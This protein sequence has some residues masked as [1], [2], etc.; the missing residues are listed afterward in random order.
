[1]D[2]SGTSKSRDGS[3]KLPPVVFA[4]YAADQEQLQHAFRL[5]ESIRTFAGRFKDAPVWAYMPP[6]LFNARPDLVERLRLLGVECRTS[7]APHESLRFHYTGKVFASGDAEASA[8]G[9][10]DLLVWMDSDTFVLDEP[11]EFAIPDTVSFAYRPV[12]HNRSGSAWGQSPDLFWSR[13]Y[14][15]LAISDMDLF[16][17]K[18]PADEIEIRT[19]FNAGLVIVR[20]ER[21]ILRQWVED[22][23]LLYSDSTLAEMCDADIEKRIFIHQTALVGA[24][25]SVPREEMM[26]LS[27]RYNYPIFFHRQFHAVH[28]FDS[29]ENIVTLRYDVYF[30]DPDPD[31]HL[32]LK[33]PKD[34]IDWLVE[35]LGCD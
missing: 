11:K 5:S 30:R 14:E 2:K 17:M 16:R 24:V 21:G 6:E 8:C 7:T 33:G 32:Q 27:D 4:T 13:I 34:R 23:M 9:S 26:E 18:T 25:K 19:Y 35:R 3:R 10:A 29:I 22:F 15:K 28:E 12:M 1:M 31:W 20:P